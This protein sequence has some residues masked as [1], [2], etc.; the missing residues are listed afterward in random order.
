MSCAYQVALGTRR[1]CGVPVR[2]NIIPPQPAAAEDCADDEGGGDAHALR[3]A[4][5]ILG[6]QRENERQNRRHADHEVRQY[7]C[8]SEKQAPSCGREGAS[9]V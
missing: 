5:A 1:R 4:V 2:R 8:S 7:L 3:A 9:L 6:V